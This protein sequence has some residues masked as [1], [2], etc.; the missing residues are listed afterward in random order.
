VGRPVW[1]V[2]RRLG[3]PASM[4]G[5]LPITCQEIDAYQRVHG[6]QLTPWELDLIAAFDNV[7]LE[8]LNKE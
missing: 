3:R 2:F 4:S 5:V 8:F 7:A 6:V 1:E